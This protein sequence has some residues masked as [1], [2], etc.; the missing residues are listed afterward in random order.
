VALA[1]AA[2]PAEELAGLGCATAALAAG[3]VP[4]PEALADFALGVV[5]DAGGFV[6]GFFDILVFR[7]SSMP[8]SARA[9]SR[10]SREIRSRIARA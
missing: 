7:S 10:G 9:L 1:G 2:G 8:W 5:A 3:A 4:A 6:D